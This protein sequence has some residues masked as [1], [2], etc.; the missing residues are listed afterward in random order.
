[1]S[2]NISEV[3]NL[4]N[5]VVT[6]VKGN[7]YYYPKTIPRERDSMTITYLGIIAFT[8]LVY[9]C[10][11]DDRSYFFSLG[12]FTLMF[13]FIVVL[14]Y[15]LILFIHELKHSLSRYA[16]DYWKML[17][18]AFSFSVEGIIVFVLCAFY[19]VYYLARHGW[20]DIP[21]ENWVI[22]V[23]LF[24]LHKILDLDN[25]PI[26]DSLSLAKGNGLDYGS[27]MAYSMFYGYLNYILPKTGDVMKNLKELM[28]DYEALGNIKFEVYKIFILIPKSLTCHVSI[29]DI[30]RNMDMRGSLPSKEL[31]V[32]GVR[33]RV[34]KNSVYSIEHPTTKKVVYVCTEYATPLKTFKEVVKNNT[35]HTEY[36]TRYKNDILL[37]FYLT[38]KQILEHEHMDDMCELVFYEDMDSDNKYHDIARILLD[39]IILIKK[40][41]QVQTA[42][43]K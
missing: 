23:L 25:N 43:D 29:A 31:T 22:I 34:Y 10:I 41:Q 35:A 30:G 7:R 18:A 19:I 12:V 8:F 32:A 27:G 1:M 11:T 2:N 21:V 17:K 20:P 38:L 33:D 6:K 40:E 24:F 15:R 36:Y 26:Y 9:I 16:N 28:Q 13:Y 3:T 42:K 5:V 14:F 39:R 4:K 37:Q